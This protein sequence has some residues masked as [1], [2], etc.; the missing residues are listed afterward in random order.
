MFFVQALSW[1]RGKL[2]RKFQDILLTI[3]AAGPIPKHVAFVM[4][5]NRRY[6]RRNNKNVQQGHSD[7]FDALKKV[8]FLDAPVILFNM[9]FG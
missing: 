6:A 9:G 4:D 1:L 8:C 2:E 5:G 7:G 3:L